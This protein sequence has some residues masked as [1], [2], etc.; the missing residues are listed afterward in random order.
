LNLGALAAKTFN[1]GGEIWVNSLVHV[2]ILLVHVLNFLGENKDILCLLQGLIPLFY[3][4]CSSF[5][6]IVYLIFLLKS[7]FFVG[8]T[9]CKIYALLEIKNLFSV[10]F[11]F[12][13]LSWQGSACAEKCG[14]S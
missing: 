5:L 7:A 8:V 12:A 4:G 1:F 9:C 10:L 6:N 3:L 14:Q 13:N 2:L 11:V